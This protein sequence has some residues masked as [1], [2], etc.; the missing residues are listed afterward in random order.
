MSVIR[1]I[2]W[3]RLRDAAEN[4]NF[5]NRIERN[6]FFTCFLQATVGPNFILN[7]R[8]TLLLPMNMFFYWSTKYII[9]MILFR[10]IAIQC[11]CSLR[12]FYLII[13]SWLQYMFIIIANLFICFLLYVSF[14]AV[15]WSIS[16]LQ[17]NGNAQWVLFVYYASRMKRIKWTF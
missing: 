9:C 4:L 8:A 11:K 10:V 15:L 17:Y 14:G 5:S 2:T 12:Y 16:W 3:G 13:F 1:E 7:W 6:T